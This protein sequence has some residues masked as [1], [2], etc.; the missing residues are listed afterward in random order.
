[1]RL[2]RPGCT[3]PPASAMRQPSRHDPPRDPRHH[4][5]HPRP[6]A[7]PLEAGGLQLPASAVGHGRG[8]C[9]GSRT[10]PR[11][12]RATMRA[13]PGLG[14]RPRAARRGHRAARTRSSGSSA[15]WSSSGT[16]VS[17]AERE[18]MFG[19]RR[20]AGRPWMSSRV[21]A[22][23]LRGRIAGLVVPRH[24]HI[25]LAN[26]RTAQ[27]A[28]Q[29][30]VA[31]LLQLRPRGGREREPRGQAHL[32]AYQQDIGRQ[33]E[34]VRTA[35]QQAARRLCA[36]VRR[37]IFFTLPGVAGRRRRVRADP[38]HVRGEWTHRR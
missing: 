22:A 14:R 19:R 34:T 6:H 28:S 5:A 10:A 2:I 4:Q 1:M 7:A 17:L 20:I 36:A 3:G 18:N 9:S 37:W 35:G 23:R 26:P 30:L 15:C 8:I 29:R 31:P 11:I 27:T 16:A 24:A 38:A 33:F 25:R 32:I 13:A 12:R 21:R